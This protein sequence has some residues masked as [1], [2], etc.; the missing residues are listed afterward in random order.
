MASFLSRFLKVEKEQVFLSDQGQPSS[1]RIVCMF[2]FHLKKNSCFVILPMFTRA[3]CS[4]W[5]GGLGLE[6]P[7]NCHPIS[8]I[9]VY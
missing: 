8:F 4:N 9:T 6:P 5:A 3:L 7:N 2:L 1:R